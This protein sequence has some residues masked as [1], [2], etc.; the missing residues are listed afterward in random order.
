MWKAG[1]VAL[2]EV[3]AVG[4]SLGRRVICESVYS[5]CYAH[6]CI[7]PFATDGPASGGWGTYARP[8]EGTQLCGSWDKNTDDLLLLQTG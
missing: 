7:R 1:Q 2:D 3:H 8:R 4:V 6:R 5:T